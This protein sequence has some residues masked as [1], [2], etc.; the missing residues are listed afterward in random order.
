MSQLTCCKVEESLCRR[1]SEP[2]K[3]NCICR[4]AVR[5]AWI[6]LRIWTRSCPWPCPA[7]HI[8]GLGS[9][10]FLALA[11]DEGDEGSRESSSAEEKERESGCLALLIH[12]PRNHERVL[13]RS[14]SRS[15]ESALPATGILGFAHQANTINSSHCVRQLLLPSYPERMLWH[16]RHWFL[17]AP[18]DSHAA[19]NPPPDHLLRNT[20]LTDRTCIFILTSLFFFSSSSQKQHFLPLKSGIQ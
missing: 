10:P 8:P 20:H 5:D 4:Q 18:T 7:G 14:R 11:E 2:C 6:R 9:H 13:R 15:P 3:W 16:L 12:G 17:R 19:R 1:G